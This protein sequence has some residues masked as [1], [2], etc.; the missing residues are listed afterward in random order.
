MATDIYRMSI[1]AYA[2]LAG[3]LYLVLPDTSWRPRFGRINMAA[4]VPADPGIIAAYEPVHPSIPGAGLSSRHVVRAA[5]RLAV[6]PNVVR[7][8]GSWK[9]N[10]HVSTPPVGLVRIRRAEEHARGNRAAKTR[11]QAFAPG[12]GC[13]RLCLRR[14]F[15]CGLLGL[16]C[17]AAAERGARS[18]AGDSLGLDDTRPHLTCRS[19]QAKPPSPIPGIL[20]HSWQTIQRG[21]VGDER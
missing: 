18:T 16:S 7:G 9:P 10:C 17:L 3:G 4:A 15:P 11:D 6:D 19:H 12:R 2:I 20:A 14:Q 5:E 8:R 13:D 1:A 21:C